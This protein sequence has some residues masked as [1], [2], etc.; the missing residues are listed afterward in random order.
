MREDCVIMLKFT[1]GKYGKWSL[2]G[3][4]RNVIIYTDRNLSIEK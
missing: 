1:F 4:K 3:T 2:R